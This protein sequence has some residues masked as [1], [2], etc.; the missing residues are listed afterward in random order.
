MLKA[1]IIDDEISARL[2]IEKILQ[3]YLHDVIEVVASGDN[4]TDAISFIKQYSPDIVFLDITMP[5]QSGLDLFNYFDTISFDVIF[6][7]AHQQ[8]AVDAVGLGASGYLLKPI[9]PKQIVD[10]VLKINLKKNSTSPSQSQNND[11]A[12]N[13]CKLLV[14]HQ[15]G[16]HIVSY[17]EIKAIVAD[18]NYCK[19]FKTSGDP[20]YVSRTIGSIEENLPQNHFFRTHRSCIVNLNYITEIDKEKNLILLSNIETPLASANLKPLI[21]ELSKLANNHI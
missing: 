19:I 21:E 2:S 5:H 6:I 9:K 1:V 10:A 14:N 13:T 11:A 20:L 17:N 8:Y 7:T 18:G 4:L 3:M 12:Y 15:K 16:V